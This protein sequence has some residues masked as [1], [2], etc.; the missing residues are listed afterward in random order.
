MAA[1]LFNH[2]ADPSRARAI[3]AGTQP[4]SRVHPEVLQAMG[5]VG[6]DLSQVKPQKLT[7]ELASGAQLLVTMGCGE[8]CPVVPGLKRDDWPLED[9]KGKSVERV[10]EIRNEV[11]QRVLE[12]LSARGWLPVQI[13]KATPDDLP[14]VLQLLSEAALPIAGVADHFKNFH[15][16]LQEKQVLGAAG[17]EIYGEYA[18]LRSVVVSATRRNLG[19]G[20]T[21]IGRVTT[22]LHSR[23]I[24]G[25]YLLTTTAG[26][27]FLQRG[28]QLIE[29]DHVPVTLQQSVEFTGACPDSAQT[30]YRDI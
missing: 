27:Y 14:E 13:R 18:L 12:L 26:R 11:K 15:V 19:V 6:I 3:S 5:E 10:R 17:A 22:Y 16:A 21:L 1:A 8:A 4:G 2:F 7:D 30:L 23:G 20:D 24:R 9:P 25:I 28:Y 29:R